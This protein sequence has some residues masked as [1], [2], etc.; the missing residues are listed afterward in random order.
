MGLGEW[1]GP[2]VFLWDVS[3]HLHI[4]LLYIYVHMC[5]YVCTYFHTFAYLFMHVY[6]HLYMYIIFIYIFMYIWVGVRWEETGGEEK[7]EY[8]NACSFA[9]QKSLRTSSNG[10]CSFWWRSERGG[11]EIARIGKGRRITGN[12]IFC[13]CKKNIWTLKTCFAHNS[14]I[15]KTYDSKNASEISHL[16]TN[17]K[18]GTRQWF[19]KRKVLPLEHITVRIPCQFPDSCQ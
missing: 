3:T 13:F 8:A 10:I 7:E 16:I 1:V 19:W 6:I 17:L 11:R 4:F 9:S 14:K 18:S 2:G 12:E 15:D 5:A